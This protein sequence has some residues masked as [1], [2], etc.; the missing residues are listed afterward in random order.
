MAKPVAKDLTDFVFEIVDATPFVDLS[1]WTKYMDTLP[2]DPYVK[3]GYR[4]KSIGWFRI[5]HNNCESDAGIDEKISRVNI[6]SEI[7]EDTTS[8]AKPTWVREPYSIW[9]LPQYGLQQSAAYN[10]VHGDLCRHYPAIDS[11]FI[12]DHDV[13]ALLVHYA[14]YMQWEDEVVLLQFQSI[15]ASAEQPGIPAVEGFHKDGNEHAGMLIVER[16]NLVGAAT[17]ISKDA[18]GKE[19][20]YDEAIP[21]GRLLYWNDKAIWHYATPF[22]VVDSEKGGMGVRHVVLMSA[23]GQQHFGLAKH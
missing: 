18:E 4:R 1:A 21:V 23:G 13:C 20:I 7:V 16:R 2:L 10:P 8:T 15:T 11:K 17:Q 14:N 6:A 12:E 19:L 3:E 9:H 22:T 5:K